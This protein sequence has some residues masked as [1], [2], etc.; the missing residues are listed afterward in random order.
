MHSKGLIM[1]RA[2]NFTDPIERNLRISWNRARAQARSRSQD[3]TISW[4]EYY[5]LWTVNGD[6]Y[7]KGRASDSLCLARKDPTK[8]WTYDNVSLVSRG[9]HLHQ[10]YTGVKRGP[11][12][13]NLAQQS[14]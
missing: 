13:R 5:Y 9:A 8:S 14:I 2:K 11:N 6:V 7:R 4:E 10:L 12:T 1:A 3:W